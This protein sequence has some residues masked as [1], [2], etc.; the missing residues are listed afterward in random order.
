MK[1]MCI[2]VCTPYKYIRG[3]FITINSDA[4]FFV[5][6]PLQKMVQQSLQ[7]KLTLH[8]DMIYLPSLFPLLFLAFFFIDKPIFPSNIGVNT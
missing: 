8:V 4:N 1:R 2:N 5:N 6:K 7:L 3:L